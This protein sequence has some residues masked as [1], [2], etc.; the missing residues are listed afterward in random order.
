[1]L[2]VTKN[3]DILHLK[4]NN[5]ACIESLAKRVALNYSLC[6]I[7]YVNES[8]WLLNLSEVETSLERDNS[9]K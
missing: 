7:F 4:I 3:N 8:L 6:V 5:I 1:M 9:L 2:V